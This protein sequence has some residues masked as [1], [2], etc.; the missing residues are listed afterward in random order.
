MPTT[1]LGWDLWFLWHPSPLSSLCLLYLLNTAFLLGRKATK[2]CSFQCRK[3]LPILFCLLLLISCPRA[4][5]NAGNS[6]RFGTQNHRMAWAGRDLKDHRVPTPYCGA[7]HRHQVMLLRTPSNLALNTARDE[8]SP[9]SLGNQTCSTSV[10][11]IVRGHILILTEGA[12]NVCTWNTA[13]RDFHSEIW[14]SIFKINHKVC[15]ISRIS[16]NRNYPSWAEH[17]GD[18]IINSFLLLACSA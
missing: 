8:A 3:M 15:C 9:A 6:K 5:M 16:A 2:L 14:K 13:S 11:T 17:F 10:L 12:L 7:S 4:H 1:S 18:L